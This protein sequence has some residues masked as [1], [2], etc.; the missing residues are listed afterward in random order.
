MTRPARIAIPSRLKKKLELN[1]ELDGYV[2][3]TLSD[4]EPWL[5]DNK[6]V[7][8]PEYTDHGPDHVRDVI[9]TAS[10]LIADHAW[11]QVTAEDAALIVLSSLLHD[12]A[13]HLSADG[14]VTLVTTGQPGAFEDD[15]PWPHL[16]E[17]FLSE[18]SRFDGRK[19]K[20]LF[21][22]TEP[23]HKPKFGDLGERDRLLIGEFLRR[24]H[25]RLAHEIAIHGIPGPQVERLKMHAPPR[26]A[27]LAGHVARSHGMSIRDAV[28]R[29]AGDD[30][31]TAL[32]TH[33]PYV[34]A[35]LRIAD[36][37]QVQ[38]ERAPKKLLLVRALRSPVSQGEWRLHAA[39]ESIETSHDDPESMYIKALPQNAGDFVK[40][41]R[42]FRSMQQELDET[43]AL[44]GEVYGR[45]PDLSKLSLTIR[46]IR[47]SLDDVDALAKRVDYV[48][49]QIGFTTAGADLLKL[50][51]GPLYSNQPE[52]GLRELLQNALDAV[53]ELRDYRTRYAIDEKALPKF[54]AD[55]LVT[56][57]NDRDG[58]TLTVRDRGIG[59]T[60]DVIEKYFLRAGASF[61]SSAQWREKHAD[62]EGHS[63]VVRS[64]R[65]GVG[66]LAAF[67]IGDELEVITRH[68][69]SGEAF[70]L[71]ARLDEETIQITRTNAPV[72]TTIRVRLHNEIE[73]HVGWNWYCLDDPIV[74][75]EGPRWMDSPS[76]PGL[77]SPVPPE[78]RR[79]RPEGFAAVDWAYL[80]EYPADDSTACNGIRV[81]S[82]QHDMKIEGLTYSPSLSI[83]DPDGRLPLNLRRDEIIGQLSFADDLFHDVVLDFIAF[84][85][86]QAPSGPEAMV[87]TDMLESAYRAYANNVSPYVATPSGWMCTTAGAVTD[88]S[89]VLLPR[90]RPEAAAKA[91]DFSRCTVRASRVARD[92]YDLEHGPEYLK[93]WCDRDVLGWQL[94]LPRLRGDLRRKLEITKRLR[95]GEFVLAFG[96]ESFDASI[97]FE[98]FARSTTFDDDAVVEVLTA[99]KDT[100]GDRMAVAWLRIVGEFFPS[101]A[102]PYRL[103]DRR[104]LTE[105]ETFRPYVERHRELLRRRLNRHE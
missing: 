10:S 82:R 58:I 73:L 86:V 70:H 100:E 101:G 84:V 11:R 45:F 105:S 5:E 46:R 65:F 67:L 62:A 25:G 85:A 54:D 37:I 102:I 78:W 104:P 48:P 30:R 12:C 19:L 44:L 69:E 21:G 52:V 16:W 6:L 27:A 103:D 4:F 63:R 60:L 71:L 3:S 59:M 13:M 8:F 51:V 2:R 75:Y 64:G 56:F 31:R 28:D 99:R 90:Q 34:M 47:S 61:R 40:A 42:L 33:P 72:G 96:G 18:A 41:H 57:A 36:Y 22:D 94:L 80:G 32:G 79:L 68:A 29:L 98:R 26:F 23:V 55:V 88:T 35:L 83:F 20:G 91:I 39:I 53:L 89:V 38:S 24:H 50:L 14:F 97:D 95:I 49:A 92:T 76:W 9:A 87:V 7:F 1:V 43:W 81:T 93:A 17:Q 15:L 66:A 77:A 74:R